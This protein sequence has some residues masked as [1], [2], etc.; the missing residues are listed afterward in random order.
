MLELADPD[1]LMLLG[2]TGAHDATTATATS[3]RAALRSF[4]YA[5][6][7]AADRAA[8]EA[9]ATDWTALDGMAEGATF[10]QSFAWCR[11][12]F[13]HHQR[14][15]RDFDPLV[16]VFRDRGQLLGLLPLQLKKSGL[17]MIATG[18][19]EPYQ[20]YTDVVLAPNAP[21]H[22]AA[23]LLDAAC[24]LPK[25]SGV[26]LLKVRDDSALAPLLAARQAIRSN[27]DAAP[28]VDLRPHADFK[29][30]L[31]TRNAKTRKN[32]RNTKNRMARGGTLDHR[33]MSEPAEIAELIARTHAGRERWLAAQGLTSRAFRD[34]TF[35]DFTAA[36]GSGMK[37]FS[38]MA[39]SLTLDGRPIADQWGF[40]HNGRYYAYVAT[41]VPEHEEAS[42][43]KLHLEQ[44]IR[45]CHERGVEVADF[46]MPA[47]RYKFTWTD[48]AVTVADYA[49]PLS[50]GARLQFS[51][52]S[53]RVRPFLKRTAMKLPSSIRS[54]LAK[55]LLRH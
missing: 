12:V 27:E 33:V 52:W 14:S 43:G 54:H 23:R 4:D 35:G 13:D 44:V 1:V 51:L 29:A 9:L 32:M 16:L 11:A 50:L 46:L 18:F 48:D 39:M 37:G 41:W 17:A 20:Q 8:F 28:F 3:S 34:P 5:I 53:G 30:Y 21:A 45:S 26:N 7:V 2:A 38:V 49:F 42:P 10:F 36:V 6:C 19:G 40:V 15:G 24:R 31:S 47:A 22:A 55:V 25:V